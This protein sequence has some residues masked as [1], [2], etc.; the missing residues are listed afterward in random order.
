VQPGWC[1]LDASQSPE[2]VSA[3]IQR[4]IRQHCALPAGPSHG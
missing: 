3:A 1:R 4:A 2:Q